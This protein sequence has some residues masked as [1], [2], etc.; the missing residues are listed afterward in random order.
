M[1]VVNSGALHRGYDKNGDDDADGLLY[2]G[3]DDGKEEHKDDEDDVDA[4]QCQSSS[5]LSYSSS[6]FCR[7]W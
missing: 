3:G 1:L 5:S 4:V 6:W 2:D 7:P